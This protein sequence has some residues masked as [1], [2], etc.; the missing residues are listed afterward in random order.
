MVIFVNS[1]KKQT[2]K[3]LLL[4]VLGICCS[5]LSA[6]NNSNSVS[7]GLSV[8]S[9]N[10][11][12]NFGAFTFVSNSKSGIEGTVYLFNGW[13]NK[14]IIY[15]LEGTNFT[16]QN[17]NLNLQ[18]NTFES[19][20]TS[21]SLFTFNFNGIEKFEINT[22]V[23]KNFY[24]NDDNR[25]FEIIYENDAFTL[26]KGFEIQ[27][28]EGSANPMLN[29][30]NDKYVKKQSYFIKRDTEIEPFKLNR[31]ELNKLFNDD[32]VKVKKVE[33][34]I[35]TDDLSSGEETIDL[36]SHPSQVF[37][38]NNKNVSETVSSGLTNMN[39][40]GTS[41]YFTNPKRRVDGSYYLF[42]DWRNSARIY[43]MNSQSFL[44]K[45]INL[46]LMRNTF[47]T[48]V[49][50]DSLFTFNFNNIEKIV[51]N[52]KT[53]KN[54]Y[55]NDDNRVCEVIFES[56][57]YAILKGFKVELVEGSANPMLNRTADK[58]VRKRNYFI[59]TKNTVKPFRLKKSRVMKLV[60]EHKTEE[61][62]AYAKQNKL[63][64]KK[65]ADVKKI[66]EFSQ[67]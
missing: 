62:L 65:E 12:N 63:S 13:N 31:K 47:E 29:R 35:K 34:Y 30:K 56:D 49:A 55:Y 54:Y 50:A 37:E 26:M 64:F 57:E 58:Y 33:N 15:T 27:I 5:V 1:N 11:A 3:F 19:K 17:I 21:D 10:N 38:E 25:V 43:V 6:Q 39:S 60:A 22:K 24:Y 18:R 51:I 2:M 66:L 32:E 8:I 42:N 40:H 46:N 53:Y 67:R 20:I 48:K 52:N 16:M 59:K 9:Q 14:T 36:G 23:F 41:F 44:L 7:T 61:I 45:N 28:L 4:S